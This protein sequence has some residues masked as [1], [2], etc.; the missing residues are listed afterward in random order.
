VYKHTLKDLEGKNQRTSR[1]SRQSNRS[2][3]DSLK[4][5]ELTKNLKKAEKNI[6][7]SKQLI[8]NEKQHARNHS[9]SQHS[10]KKVK[11]QDANST[12]KPNYYADIRGRTG[13]DHDQPRFTKVQSP[14]A[15]PSPH[16][17]KVN[18]KTTRGTK[19]QTSAQNR[20][21][22]S[23]H[24]SSTYSKRERSKSATNLDGAKKVTTIRNTAAQEIFQPFDANKSSA[25]EVGFQSRR[26]S[27]HN[28]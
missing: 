14:K 13:R 21:M 2:R 27:N 5:S 8:S 10:F 4:P 12:P 9:T 18:L 17:T 3:S 23:E 28:N 25:R 26:S 15:N 7:K 19:L 22:L 20:S 16:R 6:G 11:Q 1:N 24:K